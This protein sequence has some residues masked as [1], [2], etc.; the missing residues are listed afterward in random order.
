MASPELASKD[1]STIDQY[2]TPPHNLEAEQALLGSALINK[3]AAD[4]LMEAIDSNDFYAPANE[5]IFVAMKELF[6]SGQPID[7][8]TVSEKL[9]GDKKAKIPGP[10]YFDRLLSDLPSS[11]LFE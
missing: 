8:V 7:V 3:E 2:K 10:Q 6:D 11:G 9:L 4:R 1:G 5:S